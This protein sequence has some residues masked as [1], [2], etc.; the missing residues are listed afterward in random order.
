MQGLKPGAKV[1]CFMVCPAREEDLSFFALPAGSNIILLKRVRY[2]DNE[3]VIIETNYFPPSLSA[4]LDDEME[5]SL[6]T[7]LERRQ[8]YPTKTS[9][10]IDIC[11]ST[12]EHSALLNSPPRSPLLLVLSKVYDREGKP[13][14]SSHQIVRVDSGV[15][16][17]YL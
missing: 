2:A 4:I 13:L 3:P 16:S 14:I 15:F 8:I 1:L 9:L 11:N 10:F 17:Y 12:D 7:A 6:Y 5:G